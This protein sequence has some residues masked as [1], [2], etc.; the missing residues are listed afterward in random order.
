MTPPQRG[1]YYWLLL[2]GSRIPVPAKLG[3]A[4][5]YIIGEPGV[6]NETAIDA[7][8]PEIRHDRDNDTF[9]EYARV[10]MEMGGDAL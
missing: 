5:W 9:V 4:G 10:K 8:G 2:Q 3:F 6:V 7:A 1:H